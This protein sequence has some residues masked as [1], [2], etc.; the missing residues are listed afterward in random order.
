MAVLRGEMG[1]QADYTALRNRMYNNYGIKMP[2]SY[3]K[4]ASQLVKRSRREARAQIRPRRYME[5]GTSM[6]RF[7]DGSTQPVSDRYPALT[8]QNISTRHMVGLR[9]RRRKRG[10]RGMYYAGQVTGRGGFFRDVAKRARKV[11]SWVQRNQ[12]NLS[13]IGMAVDPEMT[14][15]TQAFLNSGAGKAATNLVQGRGKYNSLF[16]QEVDG[17]L[18]TYESIKSEHGNLIVEGQEKV[19]DIFGNSLLDP[20]GSDEG[21]TIPFTSFVVNCSPGNFQHFPKL[22]QHAANFKEYEWIS[23]IFSYKSTMPENYQ[24]TEVT[25]GRI[26]M[27]TEYDL[28]RPE[29]Q[30]AGE[31]MAQEQKVSGPVTGITDTSR[32]HHLGVECDPKM[33][34]KRALKFVRTKGLLPSD[35]P[36]D[37]SNGRVTFGIQ[38]TSGKLAD[39]LVGELWVTYRIHF[40]THRMY[41]MLGYNIPQTIKVNQWE[42]VSPHD[43]Q[44]SMGTMIDPFNDSF[45]DVSVASLST[46]CMINGVQA[47]TLD[48]ITFGLWDFSKSYSKEMCYNNVDFEISNGNPP[49]SSVNGNEYPWNGTDFRYYEIGDTVNNYV[50]KVWCQMVKFTFPSSLQGNYEIVLELNANPSNGIFPN[51]IATEAGLTVGRGIQFTNGMMNEIAENLVETTGSVLLNKDQ[52]DPSDMSFKQSAFSCSPGQKTTIIKLHLNLQQATSQVDNTVNIPVPFFQTETSIPSIKDF[53]FLT[54]SGQQ[55]GGYTYDDEFSD[56]NDKLQIYSSSKVKVAQYNSY[57]LLGAAGFPWKDVKTQQL[58]T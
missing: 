37:Y 50:R 8:S 21:P 39:K 10:R 36:N 49:N 48:Q 57:Q 16:P 56:H 32:N 27:A 30:T 46:K 17:T 29:W 35:D 18:H 43:G 41:S 45:Q 25:T 55:H 33:L 52:I 23:L 1:R 2:K 26:M 11:G 20:D 19:S 13:A 5:D 15:A 28:S 9:A 53:F 14:M 58:L 12:N 54:G 38:E 42:L 7:E 47:T 34:T 44:Y 31:I 4:A 3:T 6:I 51:S 40:K 22:A 24:T